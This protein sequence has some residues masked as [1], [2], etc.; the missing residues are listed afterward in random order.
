MNAIQKEADTR[1]WEMDYEAQI[2]NVRVVPV[3]IRKLKI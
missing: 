3:N 2:K 1:K